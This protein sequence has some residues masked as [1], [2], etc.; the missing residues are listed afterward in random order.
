M[1]FYSLYLTLDIKIPELDTEI[2]RPCQVT[3]P[4]YLTSYMHTNE[5]FTNRKEDNSVHLSI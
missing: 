3:Y 1:Y 4:Y 5:K 2:I